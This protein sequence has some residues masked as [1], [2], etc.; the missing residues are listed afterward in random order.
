M[1]YSSLF[2]ISNLSF[3]HLSSFTEHFVGFL[4]LEGRKWPIFIN[5]GYL[6]LKLD[7]LN[8]LLTDFAFWIDAHYRIRLG[9]YT[10]DCKSRPVVHFTT[11]NIALPLCFE[12]ASSSMTATVPF[13]V[14]PASSILVDLWTA[15]AGVSVCATNSNTL[16]QL[17]KI[18]KFPVNEKSPNIV[19]QPWLPPFVG[20]IIG[21]AKKR[22]KEMV[23]S[24]SQAKKTDNESGKK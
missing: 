15:C 21:E 1:Q 24:V 11:L 20:K 17:G 19:L 7:T 14:S 13:P 16:T 18:P 22:A 23:Y 6:C 4:D 5:S 12:Y 8:S 3:P 10:A 2:F 9:P